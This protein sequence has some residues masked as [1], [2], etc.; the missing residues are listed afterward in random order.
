[1]T[2]K[3]LASSAL[4]PLTCPGSLAH[5]HSGDCF[6]FVFLPCLFLSLSTV[7][8]VQLFITLYEN[9]VIREVWEVGS[10]VK[11]S[12]MQTQGPE[13]KTSELV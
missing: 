7:S 1:M 3:P 5:L 13:F 4:G 10:M 6:F 12:V 8:L 2:Q 11:V 9:L